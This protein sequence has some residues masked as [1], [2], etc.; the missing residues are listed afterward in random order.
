MRKRNCYDLSEETLYTIL[1]NIFHE[2]YVTDD[3]LN[4]LYV[5]NACYRHYGLRPEEMIGCNHMDFYGTYWYPTILPAISRE[6]RR[7]C[8]EQVTAKGERII[9]TAV[10]IL[11]ENNSIKMVVS[12]VQEEISS[13]DMNIMPQGGSEQTLWLKRGTETTVPVSDIITRSQAMQNVLK[14]SRKVAQSDIA[15][16][17]GGDSGTGKGMLAHYIHEHSPRS[18][19]PFLSINCAAI[20]EN[21]LE[22]ELFGYAPYAF[23]G[24]SSKGKTGL[25][26]MAE[27]GTLFLDEVAELPLSLQGKLLNVVESN[28]YMQVGG[29]EIK[30]SDVRIISATNQNLE[31]MIQENTFREDLFWRLNIVDLKIPSLVARREDIIPLSSYYLNFYNKKYKTNKVI[32]EEVFAVFMRY[33]WPGN[34]R[35]LRNI[36]ERAFVLSDRAEIRCKDL[37]PILLQ[38]PHMRTPCTESAPVLSGLKAQLDVL[39]RAYLASLCGRYRSSRQLASALQVSQSKANR[40]M[41]K[42]RCSD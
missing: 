8:I 34:V 25:I 26:E 29:K 24:A 12:V 6:R 15:V 38:D 31:Q 42:H 30:H 41:Q 21:L 19:Y 1:E 23:T 36:I 22:S 39:E 3:S 20:P 28:Q 37:P 16:L 32:T 40:L 5:N 27:R 35:Q 17:I 18:A 11:D 10:P 9:S 7:M 13:L 33:Q 2:I 4:I 14:L